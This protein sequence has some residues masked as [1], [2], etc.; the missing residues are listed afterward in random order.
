MS[1]A[2]GRSPG[3]RTGA[4]ITTTMIVLIL[5][6]LVVLGGGL[7]TFFQVN[8]TEQ[9]VVTRLGRYNRTVGP[10]LQFKMPFGIEQ[11]YTVPTEVIQ[12]MQF[13]YRVLESGVDTVFDTREYEE[14]SSMLTGDV[15]IVDVEWAVQFRIVDPRQWLFNMEDPEQTISDISKSVINRLV[16]D[17]SLDS[18]L[19]DARQE[20]SVLARDEMNEILQS[21]ELG[22]N[23][24][25]VELKNTAPP[26]GQ[27]EEAFKDVQDAQQDMERSINEGQQALNTEIPKARG[28][29]EQA[30]LAAR[31]YA[32]RRINEAQ[33]DVARFISVLGEYRNDPNTTRTRLYFEMMEEVFSDAEGTTLV[34]K[35]LSN[36]IPLLNL[37]ANR[38]GAQ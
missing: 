38:G 20:I 21:Y 34:D 24:T 23:I 32:T 15:N 12:S 2:N 25:T 11:Q 6:A 19:T 3:R 4:V 7:S 13:G 18:V 22:V 36:F 1:D 33:G 17:R 26:T 16:G 35:D 28:E 8:A 30:I 9:A 10:G 27:V 14:E 31:G 29:R 5:V 37:D